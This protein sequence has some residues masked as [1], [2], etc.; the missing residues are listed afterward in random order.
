MEIAWY[1]PQTSIVVLMQFSRLVF[2][3]NT[4]ISNVRI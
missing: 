3:T 1:Q 2:L 4:A